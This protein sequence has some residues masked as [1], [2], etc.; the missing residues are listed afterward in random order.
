MCLKSSL[1]MPI[2]FPGCLEYDIKKIGTHGQTLLNVNDA[3]LCHHECRIDADCVAW[4]YFPYG[5]HNFFPYLK[6]QL[7][8][9]YV[10]DDYAVG[11]ISG[12]KE[13]GGTE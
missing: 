2:L 3:S 6:C 8:T 13:C 4:Y 9:L 12:M 1:T 7:L 5:N 10:L 11:A